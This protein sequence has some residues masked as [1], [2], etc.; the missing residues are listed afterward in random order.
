MTQR[1]L[2]PLTALGETLDLYQRAMASTPA[3]PRPARRA[4]RRSVAAPGA[5]P[6]PVARRASRFDDVRFAY[7]DGARG[8]ARPR[9]RRPRRR[10]PRHRRRHR[11]RASRTV[12]KLLLRLYEPT[13]GRDHGRRRAD[14]REL[15]LRRR[16]AA[17][18]ASSARTCSCSTAPSRENIAYGAPGRHRRARSSEAAAPGRGPRLHRGP[19][20]RATTPWSA[21]AGQKLSGGQRQRL[22]DRPGHPPRPGDPGARRGDL[23]PSTTRPRPP[24][25]ARWRRC[26]RTAPRS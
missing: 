4:S 17:R 7:G 23:A 9:P 26:R 5:L 22:A 12:V 10:D 3:H 19:A 14:V 11:R 24:S 20:R 1:L 2:W 25:S 8:A 13:G 15:D 21:S 6:A 16:C 18:S